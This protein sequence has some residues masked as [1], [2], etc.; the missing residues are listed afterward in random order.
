MVGTTF[1]NQLQ[2]YE[3]EKKFSLLLTCTHRAPDSLYTSLTVGTGPDLYAQPNQVALVGSYG[4][5]AS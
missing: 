1:V 5:R 2:V 3:N 4:Q